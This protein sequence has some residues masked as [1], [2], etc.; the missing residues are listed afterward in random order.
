VRHSIISWDCCYR[1]FFHTAFT[2]SNQE[3]DADDYE[4]IY[5]EQRTEIA[6]D[7]F[8]RQLGL[9]SLSDV[10]RALEKHINVRAVYMGDDL[11][12]PLHWGRAVNR[13]IQASR[14]EV[15]SVMD[16]DLLLERDFLSKLNNEHSNSP[17]AVV[18]LH[19]RMVPHAIGVAPE[20]W[21]EQRVTFEACLDACPDRDR[22]LPK[23]PN[24][25]GPMISA[26]REHWDAISGYDEHR[27]WSTGLSL[28]GTDVTR[29]LEIQA[30]SRAYLLPDTVCVHPWHPVGFRRD[31]LSARRIL[32]LQR[33]LIEW[34]S[35]NATSHWRERLAITES[36][37]GENRRLV[38]RVIRSD[39]AQ[40]SAKPTRTKQMTAWLSSLAAKSLNREFRQ[41]RGEVAKTVRNTVRSMSSGNR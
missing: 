12:A 31:T 22:P 19:R 20:H 34:A 39:V 17:R 7:R 2:L 27:I 4:V 18:N 5:V 25:Y 9:S 10:V 33:E 41:M 40:P 6:S 14:G 8:N 21:T 36:V 16:G 30:G 26:R 35:S 11:E 13:G 23:S 32:S 28:L 3:F 37:Y 24:N 1:N 29:R 15:V 38:E